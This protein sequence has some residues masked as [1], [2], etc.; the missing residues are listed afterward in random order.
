MKLY[1]F[2][3]QT[4]IVTFNSRRLSSTRLRV[5][6]ILETKGFD[7][8]MGVLRAAS[9]THYC[10]DSD[11]DDGESLENAKQT[12]FTSI[13]REVRAW[14]LLEGIVADRLRE[15]PTTFAQDRRLLEKAEGSLADII[16]LRMGEKEVLHF[17]LTMARK[18]SKSLGSH[19]KRSELAPYE[20]YLA[21]LELEG[22]T[23]E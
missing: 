1:T 11:S 21:S 16:T 18:M 13:E 7:D 2:L 10:L 20:S 12:P 4:L 15:Y 19:S 5:S 14:Q 23:E 8:M 3:I 6:R 9:H 17:Y 22:R